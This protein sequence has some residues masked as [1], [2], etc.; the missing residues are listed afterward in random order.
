MKLQKA[1]ARALA[2]RAGAE[3]TPGRLDLDGLA[4]FKAAFGYAISA[5]HWRRLL[6]RTIERDAGAEN[7]QRLELYLDGRAFAAP[8]AK[9]EVLRAEYQHRDLDQVV[10]SLEDR[11]NPTADDRRF[12]WDAVFR[13]YEEQSGQLPDSPEGNYKRRVVKASLLSYVFSAFP[14][15]TLCATLPSLKRRF[16]EKLDQWRRGGRT[17]AALQDRRP[18]ASGR[19]RNRAF[20]EDLKKIRNL[21]IQLDG[22]E[23]LAHRMLREGG[24]LSKEFCEAHP[25]D[26][27]S[28]KSALPDSV[29]GA[30]GP[31]VNMCLPLRRGPWQARMRGPYIP[32]DWSGVLPGDWFNADDVTWNHWFKE[33]LSSGRWILTRGECLLMTDLRTGYPL[34]FLLIPDHYNGEHVRSLVL[35]VHDTVGLPRQ[36]FYFEKGVWAS[37]LITGDKRQ[38]TPVHWRVAENGLCCEGLKLDVRH[39]TTPR[40]KP[41][42]GLL[43]ILQERMRCIPGFVGFN[44]RLYDAERVQPLIARAQR[45][46][47][48]ALAS[49]PTAP[50]W[51]AKISAVLQEFS[52]EPQNGKMLQGRAPA[53]VWSEALRA[54]PLRK[55][56]DDSRFFL[57][58]HKKTVTV[59]QEGIVL[60]IRGKR[61][62]YYNERTGP[63]IGREVLAFY[64]LEMPDLLTVCDIKRQNYFSVGRVELPAMS[65]TPEQFAEVNKLR[66]GHMAHA[67]GIFGELQHEVVC[68]IT[69]DKEHSED[70]RNLG[71]FH[72][73]ET[74]RAQAEKSEQGR[75]MRRLQLELA[76]QGIQPSGP[77]RDVDEALDAANKRKL[78]LARLEAKEK[79][80]AGTERSV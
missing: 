77:V 45:G 68:T 70:S 17:P 10:A 71:R 35:K 15:G 54:R 69:R 30:I 2:L 12:L 31:E 78:Y 26:V 43:H 40:A 62:L 4:D 6:H 60:T 56:A 51:A 44:E 42:E 66:K 27:R 57:S 64:N 19:F 39:A 24:Q 11:Q 29:R 14:E 23:A 33:K 9:R 73:E 20:G 28:A 25:Y 58:T 53:E 75:K 52:H 59:H 41:I 21:A 3:A 49:F 72:N 63:L 38:G 55:L 34:D 5:R 79:H 76:A 18:L 37:R 1:L 46:D 74:E 13:G 80:G 16:E 36:G 32:R 61:N 50:E 22:N 47:L 67:K 48:E 8:K 65:A 7:W